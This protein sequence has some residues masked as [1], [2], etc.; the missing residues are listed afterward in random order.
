M[1]TAARALMITSAFL[2]ASCW[3]FWYDDGYDGYDDGWCECS[4]Y[5]ETTC[6]GSWS[7]G[8]C[9]DG[10][11]YSY[12]DCD[13]LCRD[14]GYEGSAGC[15]WDTE[16]YEYVCWCTDEPVGTCDCSWGDTECWGSDFVMS[17]DD[18]CTWSTWDCFD[19]CAESGWTGDAECG[20][21]S[22]LGDYSCTCYEE[23]PTC[24]CSAGR[25]ECWD[26]WSIGS[27]DDGCW[28]SV[29]DCDDLC[30]D[31]GW[32]YTTG[33]SYDYSTSEDACFCESY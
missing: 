16:S 7:L 14:V 28:W 23:T 24:D 33:C 19:L 26:D 25:M 13:S 1:K 18:G 12:Y 4:S 2:A 22:A 17:C 20:W 30:V 27:C 3:P 31:S 8:V 6:S 10:C 5:S 11:D 29:Y 32:D 15:D 21:D 9:E